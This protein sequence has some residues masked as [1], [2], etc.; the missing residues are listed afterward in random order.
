MTGEF[1]YPVTGR[2]EAMNALGVD[3]TYKVTDDRAEAVV[4]TGGPFAEFTLYRSQPYVD[5]YSGF[6][7]AT[8]VG[9]VNM[10]QSE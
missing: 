9:L 8:R 5:E 4:H 6:F 2:S 3:D 1:L 7:A 10:E